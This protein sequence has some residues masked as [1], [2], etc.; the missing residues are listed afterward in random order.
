MLNVALYV[1]LTHFVLFSEL[2]FH[3][4]LPGIIKLLLLAALT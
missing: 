4:T 2:L 1:R 3:E